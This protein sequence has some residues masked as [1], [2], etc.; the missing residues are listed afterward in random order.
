MPAEFSEQRASQDEDEM[1]RAMGFAEFRKQK[2][3][4]T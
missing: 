1:M 4:R 3:Q 2:R